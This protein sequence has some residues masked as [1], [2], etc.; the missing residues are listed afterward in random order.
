MFPSYQ[1]TSIPTHGTSWFTIYVSSDCP[2]LIPNLRSS[3]STSLP[4][5]STPSIMK[6]YKPSGDTIVQFYENPSISPSYIHS[7]LPPYDSSDLPTKVLS[8]FPSLK[9]A[10]RHQLRLK[11][12]ESQA[13]LAYQLIKKHTI[14]LKVT[15]NMQTNQPTLSPTVK[16]ISI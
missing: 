6:I 8:S 15:K 3:N 2:S 1:P 7:H 10:Y 13:Q 4:L 16:L 11:N 12:C 9:L 5:S 14:P